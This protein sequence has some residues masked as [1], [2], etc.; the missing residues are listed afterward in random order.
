[1]RRL[2]EAH[3]NHV[4]VLEFPTKNKT[5]KIILQGVSPFGIDWRE[6]YC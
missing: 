5:V 6:K 2:Q 1:M 3:K 4:E